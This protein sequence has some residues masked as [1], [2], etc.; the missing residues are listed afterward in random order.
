MC[1][2]KIIKLGAQNPQYSGDQYVLHKLKVNVLGC[3]ENITGDIF[4][5]TIDI[6][7]HLKD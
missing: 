5:L 3:S 1:I 6:F 7:V 2:Q 4:D